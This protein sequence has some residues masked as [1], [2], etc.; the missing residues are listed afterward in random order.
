MKFPSNSNGDFTTCCRNKLSPWS[1][2]TTSNAACA[3]LWPIHH[4]TT[5]CHVLN[6]SHFIQ[7]HLCTVTLRTTITINKPRNAI[8]RMVGMMV[9]KVSSCLFLRA[10]AGLCQPA[11]SGYHTILTINIPVNR[12][13]RRLGNTSR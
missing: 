2:R 8:P 12:M 3:C 5:F 1:R 11:Q 10:A 6:R 13:A 7:A 9:L 4:T